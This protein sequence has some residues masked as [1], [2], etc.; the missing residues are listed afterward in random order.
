MPESTVDQMRLYIYKVYSNLIDQLPD[1][2]IKEL[3]RNVKAHPP[4]AIITREKIKP[5]PCVQ[6]KFGIN[7]IEE[8]W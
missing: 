4:R 8:D 2:R 5:D 3:Y 1:W 7:G 6:L